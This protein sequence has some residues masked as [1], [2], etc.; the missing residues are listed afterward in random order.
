MNT[1]AQTHTLWRPCGDI[2]CTASLFSPSSGVS[3]ALCSEAWFCCRH[4]VR[5]GSSCAS[6][7]FTFV[8]CFLATRLKH[9]RT[10]RGN[11][12]QAFYE[13]GSSHSVSHFNVHGY[14]NALFSCTQFNTEHNLWRPSRQSWRFLVQSAIAIVIHHHMTQRS[15]CLISNVNC[16]KY[17][18]A[19]GS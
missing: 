15:K 1:H 12:M 14:L 4:I 5:G 17:V 3:V 6:I 7:A 9:N 2:I 11:F 19:W 8:S 13:R 16:L 10:C 18:T